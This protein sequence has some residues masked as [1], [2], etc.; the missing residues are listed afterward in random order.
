[1]L[2]YCLLSWENAIWL[3]SSMVRVNEG[4]VCL[5]PVRM[6]LDPRRIRS[7]TSEW[8]TSLARGSRLVPYTVCGRARGPA[9]VHPIQVI[10]A[11]PVLARHRRRQR[12]PVGEDELGDGRGMASHLMAAERR[13]EAQLARFGSGDRP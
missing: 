2:A 12:R 11:W 1:M 4:P 9:Y 10:S 6:E 13:A 7:I 5:Y 3:A 8:R